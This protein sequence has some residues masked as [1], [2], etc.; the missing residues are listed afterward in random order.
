VFSKYKL[1]RMPLQKLYNHA[2]D[3]MEGTK[4]SKP[5]KVYLLSL[6]ERNSLDTWINKKLRKGYICLSTSPIAALFSFV[7]KHDGSLQPIIDYRALN[8]ITIKNCY[9]IPKI[10]DLIK[11]LSKA[12]IFTKIDLRWRYNNVCIKEENKW[13]TVFITRQGL[14]EATVMYFGFSNVPVTF[15]SMMNNILGDLICIRLVMVYLDNILI[16]GTCLKEHR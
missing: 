14:F 7:K 6:A 3:F 1:E 13:K 11:S 4:F 16:F 2:I 10:A 8:A 15:Q 9:P 12:L 5:A